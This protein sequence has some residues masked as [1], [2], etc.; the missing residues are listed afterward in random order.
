M[1]LYTL[2]LV[3]LFSISIS[4]AHE[5]YSY[6]YTVVITREHELT[7]ERD[8]VECTYFMKSGNHYYVKG[9]NEKDY[10]S[11][12]PIEILGRRKRY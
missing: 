8:T 12:Q 5:D 4:L 3:L 6:I 10:W 2:L 7:F 9:L 1:K 11:D